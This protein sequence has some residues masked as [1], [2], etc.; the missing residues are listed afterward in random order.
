[1]RM[2]M[3]LALAVLS[4]GCA[5]NQAPVVDMSGVD[6]A[7]YEQDLAYCESYAQ[8]VD[9]A[10][11]AA[12][13]AANGAAVGTGSGAVVGAIEDGWEGAVAGALA[14]ALVGASVGAAEGGVSSTK[15]QSLVLRRCLSEK[16]YTVYDLES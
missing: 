10:E 5:Y 16:G 13:G 12:V 15:V 4:A 2:T 11:A 8:S 1:M 7:Q 9:K 14:G 3:M 6:P